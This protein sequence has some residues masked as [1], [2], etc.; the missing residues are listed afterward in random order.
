MNRYIGLPV[1]DGIFYTSPMPQA[2]D[3]NVAPQPSQKAKKD[4]WDKAQIV[5]TAFIPVVIGFGSYFIQQSITKESVASVYVGI[6]TT[7]LERPR[8]E[9]DSDLQEWAR[10]LLVRY[11]PEP[12]SPKAQEQLE[13]G[14]LRQLKPGEGLNPGVGWGPYFGSPD[15]KKTAI[16]TPPGTAG[17]TAVL[18]VFKREP[19]YFAAQ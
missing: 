1:D 10:K 11:S 8:Q 12:F 7:I 19:P 13:S 6:A 9:G 17:S 2:S 16:I 14:G 5:A 18:Y 4:A 15:G 3:E